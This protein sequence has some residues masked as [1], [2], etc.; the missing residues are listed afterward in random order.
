[1]PAH[2]L[3]CDVDAFQRKGEMLVQGIS[4][5]Q[6]ELPVFIDIERISPLA[7]VG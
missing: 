7:L 4:D 6:I 3:A 5:A 1:V 2:I